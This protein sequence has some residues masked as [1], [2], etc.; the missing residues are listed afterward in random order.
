MKKKASGGALILLE[1][2][3]EEIHFKSLLISPQYRFNPH[4][5]FGLSKLQERWQKFLEQDKK[6]FV[7]LRIEPL[8]LNFAE[9]LSLEEKEN[10]FFNRW[11]NNLASLMAFFYP[12][13]AKLITPY[14]EIET[15]EPKVLIKVFLEGFTAR[16]YYKLADKM[17]IVLKNFNP[18]INKLPEPANYFEDV[19]ELFSSTSKTEEKDYYPCPILAEKLAGLDFLEEFEREENNKEITLSLEDIRKQFW[20]NPFRVWYEE[21]LLGQRLLNNLPII[22]PYEEF[23]EE[24][25]EFNSFSSNYVSCPKCGKLIQ[26]W[27]YSIGNKLKT[28]D[29]LVEENIKRELR[30]HLVGFKPEE[31][32]KLPCGHTKEVDAT[33]VK[34]V[35][36]DGKTYCP[37]CKTWINIPEN[38]KL[39]PKLEKL[40]QEIWFES[41]TSIPQKTKEKLFKAECGC[42]LS[43]EE[44]QELI[45]KTKK[46]TCPKCLKSFYADEIKLKFKGKY[47]V[48]PCGD[49]TSLKELL[50]LNDK[51]LVFKLLERE[52]KSFTFFDWEI[53]LSYED[54][55]NFLQR[56]LNS[57]ET[58]KFIKYYCKELEFEIFSECPIDEL[59]QLIDQ[60]TN[61]TEFQDLLPIVEKIT[62]ELG[63]DNKEANTTKSNN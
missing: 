37:K 20:T 8:E 6:A 35:I 42:Y 39:P 45:R 31:T 10:Y 21:A 27:E 29:K 62:F 28:F 19:K 32:L 56:L 16:D 53:L 14:A 34:E 46:I 59:K 7:P 12:S 15:F 40:K 24:F 57:I 33:T 1:D 3:P 9:E 58:L 11:A 4:C 23:E 25:K 54:V 60:I 55:K 47:I 2:T 44:W 49:K 48:L 38:W 18:K 61:D 22:D 43:P 63:L 50:S 41:L 17:A 51:A 13:G 26:V 36:L 5:D 30:K 52:L